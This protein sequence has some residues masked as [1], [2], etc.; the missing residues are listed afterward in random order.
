MPSSLKN[1][2][3][4]E[5]WRIAAVS[6]EGNTGALLENRVPSRFFSFMRSMTENYR[7]FLCSSDAE[8]LAAENE[9]HGVWLIVI[10]AAKMTEENGEDHLRLL[11]TLQ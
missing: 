5:L 1:T 9:L 3:N 7:R 4:L 2:S 10:E 8:R 11:F 6:N